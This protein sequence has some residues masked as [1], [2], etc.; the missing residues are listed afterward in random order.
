MVVLKGR[1]EVLYQ[2]WKKRR[3]RIHRWEPVGE[4]MEEYAATRAEAK[5]GR[6]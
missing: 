6:Q 1:L 2:T 4:A 3:E 5:E